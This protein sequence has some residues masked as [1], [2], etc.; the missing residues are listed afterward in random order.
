M[1]KIIGSMPIQ[2]RAKALEAF[3]NDPEVKCILISL[4]AGSMGLNL[5]AANHVLMV[6]PWW[7][8]AVEEQALDRI[9]RI[10]Q[11]KFVK[12]YKFITK[13]SVEERMLEIQ[14]SKRVMRGNL[15]KYDK[16]ERKKRNFEDLKEIFDLAEFDG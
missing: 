11:N 5:V 14:E 4:M 15:F 9:H 13:D 3:S 12:A 16:E 2:D 6:D 8:P 1:K 7:N 10:G